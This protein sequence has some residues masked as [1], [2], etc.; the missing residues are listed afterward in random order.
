MAKKFLCK[1]SQCKTELVYTLFGY[2]STYMYMYNRC[3]WNCFSLPLSC[4]QTSVRLICVKIIQSN[5]IY[6]MYIIIP[7]KTEVSKRKL[8][9]QINEERPCVHVQV[10][11][12]YVYIYI[13]IGTLCRDSAVG[14]LALTNKTAQNSQ[15]L[16]YISVFRHTKWPH[17]YNHMIKPGMNLVQVFI[18]TH[19]HQYLHGSMHQFKTPCSETSVCQRIFMLKLLKIWKQGI[20]GMTAKEICVINFLHAITSCN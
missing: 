2:A 10:Y 18:Y 16:R 13:R 19:L 4:K 7:K 12:L 11:T 6:I 8:Q 5:N 15:M 3:T 20:Q 9:T 1:P 17:N 14:S